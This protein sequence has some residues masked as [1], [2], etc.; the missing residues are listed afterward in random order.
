MTSPQSATQNPYFDSF[1]KKKK[2]KKCKESDIR[3]TKEMPILLNFVNLSA[4]FYSWFYSNK[5]VLNLVAMLT[6]SF[7]DQKSFF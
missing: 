6:F 4:T 1:A 7:W 3:H 5:N 2:K